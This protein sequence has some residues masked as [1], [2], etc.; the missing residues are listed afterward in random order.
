MDQN[1]SAYEELIK[2]FVRWAYTKSD[3]HM[4]LVVGSRARRDHP[5]D[6]WA[7]LDIM[8]FTTH[9]KYYLSQTDWMTDIGNVWVK[10]RHRTV[11][12]DAEWLVTFEGGF[13]VDFVFSTYRRTQWQMILWL[14]EHFTGLRR[15]LPK[16]I[17]HYLQLGAQT[18]S[19]GVRVLVDK[20]NLAS[21]MLHFMDY[22]TSISQPPSRTAFVELVEYFW[23]MAEKMAK[24]ICRGELYVA[25]LWCNYL[26]RTAVL[27]ML[28]WHG[29][30]SHD[31]SYDT[32]QEGRFL[33]EWADKRA[34]N[35]L[36]KTFPH[37][38][39]E[40]IQS[41]LI[42]MMGLFRWLAI[43]TAKQL[44]YPYP[45]TIDETITAYIL[46]LFNSLYGERWK[47]IV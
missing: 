21:S 34:L 26:H 37:Y 36:A 40:D 3:I 11:G 7:D 42:T 17:A 32:W 1:Y 24:K 47:K 44:G 13:D 23:C 38:N 30:A 31:W 25:C 33:E 39:E 45:L 5:A 12:N 15:F 8:T 18:M 9:P 20:D 35:E 43:E 2:Q 29:R 22:Y 14:T 10:T 41:S 27:P 16:Q 28:E 46:T 19:R 6:G 4:A